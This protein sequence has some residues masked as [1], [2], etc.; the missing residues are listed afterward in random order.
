MGVVDLGEVLLKENADLGAVRRVHA[1]ENRA[2][3]VLG[4]DTNTEVNATGREDPK[5]EQH[6]ADLVLASVGR[7]G[8]PVKP[9]R[10]LSS[11]V[12]VL[13]RLVGRQNQKLLAQIVPLKVV[14]IKVAVIAVVHL[15]EVDRLAC[16][17]LLRNLTL[18][19]RVCVSL[20]VLERDVGLKRL[21]NLR[22]TG[23]SRARESV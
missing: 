10:H 1:K 12:L 8:H 21:R 11:H 13:A 22:R 3:D 15:P 4:V 14:H 20:V 18:A 2:G 9:P 7:L 16:R 6:V 5:V 19:N 23:V 17:L